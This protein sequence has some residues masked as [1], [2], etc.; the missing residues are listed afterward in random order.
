[1][2]IS[3]HY[4]EGALLVPCLSMSVLNLHSA[5]LHIFRFLADTTPVRGAQFGNTELMW[6]F[7]L[8]LLTHITY[9]CLISAKYRTAWRAVAIYTCHS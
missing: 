6:Y 3:T 8:Q 9:S 1:M 5:E 7:L 2:A 4:C